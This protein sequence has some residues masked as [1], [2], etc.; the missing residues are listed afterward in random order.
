MGNLLKLLAGV[1]AAG[2]AALTGA[3]AQQ[4]S[5]PQLQTTAVSEKLS[6]ADITAIL[7]NKAITTQK[8]PYEGNE[9]A[10][11]LATTEGGGKF[12]VTLFACEDPL[13]GLNCEGAATYVAFSN[14][15]LAYD[16]INAFNTEAS[17]AKA[18]NVA[19]QNLIIFGVQR[20]YSGGVTRANVEYETLL[21]LNDMQKFF[22]DRET[23]GTAVSLKDDLSAGGAKTENIV[24]GES[25]GLNAIRAAGAM[26]PAAAL[27]VAIHNTKGVSFAISD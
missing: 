18:V 25:S 21:F 2:L 3:T 20:F 6:V 27:A 23:A 11:L 26:A 17:V 1:T 5:N 8:I 12:L 9:T 16:D 7:A 10:T 4:I 22:N 13:E 19:A 15:G 24:A 14:A